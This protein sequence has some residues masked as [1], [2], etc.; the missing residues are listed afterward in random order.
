MSGGRPTGK[1][2]AAPGAPTSEVAAMGRKTVE[3]VIADSKNEIAEQESA[4]LLAAGFGSTTLVDS[5]IGFRGVVSA[6]DVDLAVVD[7][8]LEGSS[9]FRAIKQIREGTIGKN[10]FIV[11]VMTSWKQDKETVRQAIDAGVDDFLVQPLSDAKLME[12]VSMQ[13]RYRRPFV[14]THDYIGPDRRRDPTRE[15]NAK[16]HHVPNTLAGKEVGQ[17]PETMENRIQQMRS[18]LNEERL[19]RLG[20]QIAFLTNLTVEA[21]SQDLVTDDTKSL[22][23]QMSAIARQA[24]LRLAGT[25]YEMA[26][27]L[28]E[29]MGLVAESVARKLPKPPDREVRLLSPVALAI[30]KAFHPA[31]GEEQLTSQI[32]EV[33]KK[34][35]KRMVERGG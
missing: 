32:T 24:V 15:S 2:P 35:K 10:P 12:R 8:E 1:T 34:Y 6:Y 23:L 28:C 17:K 21:I 13:I 20:F 27:A 16:R 7:A 14:V 18:H 4:T 11:I 29:Q 3:I 33:V 19:K 5:E 22:L 25:D 30:V 31:D 9:I 26:G